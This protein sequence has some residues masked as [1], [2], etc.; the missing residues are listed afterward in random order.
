MKEP[1][2]RNRKRHG[3]GVLDEDTEIVQRP[4]D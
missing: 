3:K 4:K 2:E 1:M